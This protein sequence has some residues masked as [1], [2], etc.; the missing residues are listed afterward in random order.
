MLK[1][2]RRLARAVRTRF[3]EREVAATATSEAVLS[4]LSASRQSS[5]PCGSMEIGT[6]RRYH[7]RSVATSDLP[8]DPELMVAYDDRPRICR[9]YPRY[10]P[11]VIAEPCP[12]VEHDDFDFRIVAVS[13]LPSSRTP[14]R[15][16]LGGASRSNYARSR[17]SFILRQPAGRGIQRHTPRHP[18]DELAESPSRARSTASR[19]LNPNEIEDVISAAH[20]GSR[21]RMNV[22]ASPPCAPEC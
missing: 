4:E 13:A 9:R 5:D 14:R 20:D 2:Q 21:T 8:Q 19:Q 1:Q 22:A 17:P 12:T 3:P 7:S 15:F 16:K 18:H 10:L 11:S 6:F